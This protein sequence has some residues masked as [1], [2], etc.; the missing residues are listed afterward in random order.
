MSKLSYV[1]DVRNVRACL[2]HTSTE[3]ELPASKRLLLK[4]TSLHMQDAG[5]AP[6]PFKPG[7]SRGIAVWFYESFSLINTNADTKLAKH[8]QVAQF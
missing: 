4:S 3:S 6:A 8:T 7:P 5:A 2:K 1:L